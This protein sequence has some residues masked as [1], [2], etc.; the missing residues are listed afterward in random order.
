MVDVSQNRDVA[1]ERRIIHQS[2]EEF[3]RVL[4]LSGI[5][6]ADLRLWDALFENGEHLVV[7]RLDQRLLDILCVFLLYDDFGA[8]EHLWLV[9]V[10]HPYILSVW[11][12][13]F[14]FV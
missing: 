14:I 10:F 5:L 8:F 2:C 11:I 13:L 7:E 6:V 12:V 1:R 4:L 9:H 3:G